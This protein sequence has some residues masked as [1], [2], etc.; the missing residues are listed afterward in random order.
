MPRAAGEWRKV[1][2]DSA[3]GGG[4][5]RN[6]CAARAPTTLVKTRKSPPMFKAIARDRVHTFSGSLCP[7][8]LTYLSPADAFVQALEVYGAHAPQRY[9]EENQPTMKIKSSVKAGGRAE[10]VGSGSGT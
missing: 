7:I 10:H 1:D 3:R 2:F 4:F 6:A 5:T 8:P 9:R